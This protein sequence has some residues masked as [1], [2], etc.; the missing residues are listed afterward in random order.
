LTLG[1]VR[2][3]AFLVSFSFGA[4]GPIAMNAV[5][6]FYGSYQPAFIT[7]IGLFALSAFI[8]GV[9]RPPKAKRYATAAEITPSARQDPRS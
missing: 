2:S 9:A 3:L 4:S 7:I 5:F 8:M 1:V 6:D